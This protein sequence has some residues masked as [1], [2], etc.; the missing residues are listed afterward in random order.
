MNKLRIYLF[1]FITLNMASLAKAEECIL[2]GDTAI[3]INKYNQCLANQ[4]NNVRGMQIEMNR[5]RDELRRL[6][7]ENKT[8][9]QKIDSIKLT[10][11]NIF[12]E[13]EL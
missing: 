10:L 6:T 11:K 3:E 12:L 7:E 4:M 8:L 1:A 2:D 5:L 9:K 13:L